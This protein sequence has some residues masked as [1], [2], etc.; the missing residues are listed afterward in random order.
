MD[1]QAVSTAT[2][3]PPEPG[4]LSAVPGIMG[5]SS[6]KSA[7]AD[8]S[9]ASSNGPLAQKIAHILGAGSSSSGQMTVNVSYRVEHNPDIVVTVFTDPQTGIEI[10][11]C[12]P[13][14]LVQIAQFFDKHTGVTLDRSA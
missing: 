10:A 1:V 11:Q 7:N 12:P 5:E 6:A 14:V 8:A 4:Q 13:E 2:V 9:S 3:V